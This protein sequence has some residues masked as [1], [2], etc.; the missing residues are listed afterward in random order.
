MKSMLLALIAAAALPVAAQTTTPREPKV[1]PV[2]ARAP[3]KEDKA[4]AQAKM[5]DKERARLAKSK[6]KQGKKVAKQKEDKPKKQAP[7]G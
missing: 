1:A 6:N 5:T 4:K 7:A 3:A 2:E